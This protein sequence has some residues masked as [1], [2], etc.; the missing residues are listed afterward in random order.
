MDISIV[1]PVFNESGK[2]AGDIEA[3]GG[4]LRSNDLAGEI[5]VVDDGSGDGTAEA[6]EKAGQ[7]LGV[8]VKVIR[9]GGHLGKGAAVRAG[10]IESGGE[11]V[12]FAD[13]GSCVPYENALVGLELIKNDQ[14]D[15][16]HGSRKLANSKIEKSGGLYRR[17][18]SAVF[19]QF[20]KWLMGIPAELS[21]TQC[22]F[23]IYR[24]QVARQL[25]SGCECDGFMFDIEVILR[26]VKNDYRIREFPIQWRCD[27]DSRLRP[28]RSLRG[29]I[30]EL[31]NIKRTV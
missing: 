29:I 27:S 21:D 17:M 6:A 5:I 4:F 24:G 3:A 7:D 23:K 16:A 14:C 20:I 1:I 30:S 31:I 22:G 13:S 26:A 10:I 8:E 15:I 12:M 2:I 18:C 9:L 19:G 28:M 11:Y 25:Y